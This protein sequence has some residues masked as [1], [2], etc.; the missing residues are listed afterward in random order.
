MYE[1]P[2]IWLLHIIPSEEVPNG[3]KRTVED[4]V[5]VSTQNYELMRPFSAKGIIIALGILT[6]QEQENGR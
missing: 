5:F 6:E 3:F 2:G 1:V 4:N